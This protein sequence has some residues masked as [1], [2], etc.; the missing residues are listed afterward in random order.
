LR[1][2]NVDFE[3]QYLESLSKF[4][5]LEESVVYIISRELKAQGLITLSIQS[6]IKEKESYLEKANLPKYSD[7]INDITDILGVRIICYLES[8]IDSVAKVIESCFVVDKK[9]SVDNRVPHSVKSVG[10]R[11][12]HLI[13]A[14]GA[15]RSTFAEY[16]QISEIKFEIQLRTV[17]QHAW[18]E[19]EH[20]QNYK[21]PKALPPELQRRLFILAGT[22][23][24]IDAE[25][26]RITEEA[27]LYF[28]KVKEDPSA[29]ELDEISLSSLNATIDKL[30]DEHKITE[31]RR[32]IDDDSDLINELHLFGV[33]TV[34][35]LYKLLNSAIPTL[36]NSSLLNTDTGLVRHAMIVEDQERFFKSFNG[37]YSF[38]IESLNQLS[39]ILESNWL[40]KKI[41]DGGYVVKR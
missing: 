7:P 21:N 14:L 27:G 34:G 5:N 39:D 22:L 17:L 25:L 33:S 16:S 3:T 8:E 2:T 24:G 9:N 40:A 23:E 13:C 11:S 26:S 35:S 6:R 38:N 1:G 28:S 32:N 4:K 18:A 41:K 12:L 15:D 36:Q 20:K 19:V 31:I 37:N 30:I 29:V 10:Y